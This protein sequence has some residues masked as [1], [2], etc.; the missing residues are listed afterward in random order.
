LVIGFIGLLTR[1]YT[2]QITVTHRL[3]VLVTVFT[4]VL[5]NV[6]QQ[7]T[8]LCPR[9]GGRLTRNA[10]SSNCRLRI[11][12]VIKVKVRVLCYHR[13]SVGQSVLEQSTHLGLKTRSSLLSDSC[14]LVGMGRSLTRGRACR[15]PSLPTITQFLRVTAVT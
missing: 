9:A 11:L 12:H 8:I 2:L 4:A 14:G 6:F 1:N 15:L 10:Y 5:A 13:R 7:W 3:V